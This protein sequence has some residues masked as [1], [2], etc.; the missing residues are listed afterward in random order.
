MA[1]VERTGETLNSCLRKVVPWQLIVN[2]TPGPK[3]VEVSPTRGP[4]KRGFGAAMCQGLG[5]GFRG[6]LIAGLQCPES[7]HANWQLHMG[8]LA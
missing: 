2:F 1:G 8:S 4:E 6:Q 3:T 7:S 5:F